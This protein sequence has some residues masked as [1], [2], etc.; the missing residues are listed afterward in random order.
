MYVFNCNS[1][2]FFEKKTL[3]RPQKN[4]TITFFLLNKNI[5]ITFVV[6]LLDQNPLKIVTFLFNRQ[7]KSC[8]KI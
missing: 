1:E 2:A 4:E 7:Q 6:C 3:L 8:V 5:V